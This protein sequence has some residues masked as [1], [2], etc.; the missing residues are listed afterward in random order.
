MELLERVQRRASWI[1]RGL[2]NLSYEERLREL[3]FFSWEKRRLWGDPIM[4]L[5]Y[6]KVAY[7]QSEADFLQS[8]SDSTNR[9]GFKLKEGRFILNIRRDF[10]FFFL[11]REWCGTGR[12]CTEKL[13]MPHPW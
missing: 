4:A 9:K 13:W 10:F 6:L 11:L 3:D 12:G 7:K 2:E 8:D 1:L 5:H